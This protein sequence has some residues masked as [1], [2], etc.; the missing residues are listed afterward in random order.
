[1]KKPSIDWGEVM[2]QFIATIQEAQ[3][4]AN[5]QPQLTAGLKE[6]AAA[7]L[8]EDAGS[9]NVKWKVIPRGFAWTGGQPSKMSVLLC[10][11]PDDLPSEIRAN[12]MT[13]ANDLWIAETGADPNDLLIFTTS[14]PL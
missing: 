14:Q 11:V 5:C 6:I 4:A 8:G 1:M 9:A 3:Q 7:F 12:L 13:Q 10:I 2:S